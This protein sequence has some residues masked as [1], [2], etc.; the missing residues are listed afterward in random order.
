[1]IPS[2]SLLLVMY[3]VE[4]WPADHKLPL[5]ISQMVVGPPTR[6]KKN[7]YKKIIQTQVKSFLP[8]LRYHLLFLPKSRGIDLDVQT[9]DI[10]M[11]LVLH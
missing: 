1:M 2:T 3:L 11:L 7:E 8:H 6:S 10:I 5:F 4:A 9:M